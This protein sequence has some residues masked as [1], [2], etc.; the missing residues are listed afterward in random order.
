MTKLVRL[1][2][3]AAVFLAGSLAL[4][5]VVVLKGGAVINVKKPPERRGDNVLLHRTDGT[6]LSVPLSEIDASAT[7]AARA[8]AAPPPAATPAPAATLAGAARAAREVPKARVKI[9]DAD[10]SHN[11]ASAGAAEAAKDEA[12][13]EADASAGAGRVEVAEYTQEKSGDALVV[14]GTLKNPGATAAQNVRMAVTALDGKG[15]AITSAE[16]G[17]SNAVIPP[18]GSV[19]FSATL[20]VGARPIGSIRFS[21]RWLA[22]ALPTAPAAASAAEAD[23]AGAPRPAGAAPPAAAPAAAPTASAAPPAPAPTPYG[24]GTLYAPP[25]AN[26]PSQPPADGKSG[27][28]PGASNPANQPKPPGP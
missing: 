8:A 26:A 6:L 28:L 2:A 24:R 11:E 4:A 23:A 5:D 25:A 16:A 21:P 20:S 17:T 18:G 15:Q 1:G 13:K 10:V 3:L 7:Q 12:A 14:R 19:A 9:T 27:Y 22:P